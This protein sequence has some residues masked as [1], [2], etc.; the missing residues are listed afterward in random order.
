ML[1]NYCKVLTIEGLTMIEMG[2]QDIYPAVNAYVLDL[3]RTIEHKEKASLSVSTEKKIVERLSKDNE[4]M[5]CKAEEIEALLAE[6]RSYADAAEQAKFFAEKIIPVME[7]MRAFADDME[8]Y[9][10]KKYWPFPT[11]ADILFSV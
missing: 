1:E 10:A 3:C 11:Y 7:E 4:R 2:R 8:C 6:A 5:F 9:T